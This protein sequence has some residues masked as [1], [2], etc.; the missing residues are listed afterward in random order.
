MTIGGD[1]SSRRQTEDEQQGAADSGQMPGIGD[2][3]YIGGAVKRALVLA[4]VILLIS[5]FAPQ[6]FDRLLE[7]LSEAERLRNI[8]PG[9]FILMFVAEVLSFASLWWLIRIMLPKVSWFVAAT[10]Q[11]T[12]NSVS[13]VVPG[14]GGAAAGGATLYRMLAVSGTSPTQAGGAL[15]AMSLLSTAALAAIPAIGVAI[16]LFGSPIPEGLSPIAIAS[17]V[18]CVLLL[19]VGGLALRTTRPLMLAGRVIDRVLRVA[20]RVFRKSWHLDQDTLLGERDRLAQLLGKRWP[21]ATAASALNWTF[22]YLVLVFA[23]YAVD[24][25]PRLSLVMV[26]YASGAVLSMISITPGGFGFV[27]VGL[28]G[29]LT[30][31]GIPSDTAGVAVLAYRGVS[32]W[33]PIASGL[34]AWL[35]FRVKHPRRTTLEPSEA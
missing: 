2:L 15:A 26:A 5:L 21:A 16:A 22:D 19:A 20:G 23:L 27:E 35:L 11:L 1:A 24:A 10:S 3:D 9:W 30:L 33:L 32:L 28:V 13:R 34:F 17:A 6:I 7:V 25:E 31:S 12:S 18:L 14:G 29:V 4:T 8:R